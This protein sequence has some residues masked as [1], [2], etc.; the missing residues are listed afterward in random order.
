MRGSAG[1]RFALVDALR[2]V[3]AVGVVLFHAYRRDLLPHA[4]APLPEPLHS[5]LAHGNLGVYIFFVLSGFVIAHSVRGAA[6]TP[7]FVGRFALR[8]SLRLDPPYWVAIAAALALPMLGPTGRPPPSPSA[9][10]VVAHVLYVQQFLG[11]PHLLVVF[12][13]LCLEIQFYLVYVVAM[14][15][16]QRLAGERAWLVFGALWLASLVVATEILRLRYAVFLW[17][18]PYFFL[19]ALTAWHHEGRIAT[20]TW[21][22]VT[23]ATAA[24]LPWS[25][26]PW[27]SDDDAPQRAAV[28]LAV[29]LL[30]LLAGRTRSAGRSLLQ[31]ATLGRPLQYLGRISYSLYLIHLLVVTPTA[32]LG[33]RLLGGGPLGAL[34]VLGLAL[35]CTRARIAVAHVL[36]VA[37]ERPALRL[38]R[39]IRLAAPPRADQVGAPQGSAQADPHPS[40][41]SRSATGDGADRSFR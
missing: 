18:W 30:L 37:V 23:A 5:L 19:G 12:W 7:G 27:L 17:A 26:S 34:R 14:G 4:R 40:P 22:L 9:G 33:I 24:V 41:S 38:S 31:T 32:R 16:V 20:R 15:A 6:I 11:I 21:T 8:R 3:A 1:G 35:G 10:L 29:A 28:V 13:T 36:H 39:R 2:G 25:H